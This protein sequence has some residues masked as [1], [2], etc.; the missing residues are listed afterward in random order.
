[1]YKPAEGRRDDEVRSQVET[2]RV[3]WI[4][5]GVRRA[6]DW[7]PLNV[8]K[9]RAVT[10]LPDG[11]RFDA[12]AIDEMQGPLTKHRRTEIR[13]HITDEED[14]GDHEEE[15]FG[16]IQMEMYDEEDPG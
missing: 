7:N 3:D 8:I 5:R 6:L 9:A 15:E 11:Q 1:M 4:H 14:Q 13:A 2:W 10:A 12:K 16:D